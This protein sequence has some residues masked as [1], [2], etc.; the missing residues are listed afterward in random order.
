MGKP[1]R[2][3]RRQQRNLPSHSISKRPRKPPPRLPKSSPHSRNNPLHRP[4]RRQRQRPVPTSP[5]RASGRRSS[6]TAAA[7]AS[8]KRAHHGP[9][10]SQPRDPSNAPGQE[11]PATNQIAA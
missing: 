1:P 3:P 2:L 7:A 6:T 5:R 11:A 8:R 4:R 10:P 9:R